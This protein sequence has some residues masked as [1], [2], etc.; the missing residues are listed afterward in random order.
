MFLSSGSFKGNV[1]KHETMQNEMMKNSGEIS[2]HWNQQVITRMKLSSNMSTIFILFLSTI[3]V[4]FI[5]QPYLH[6]FWETQ[7]PGDC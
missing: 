5:W 7:G 4:A 6:H 3:S 2:A 1:K